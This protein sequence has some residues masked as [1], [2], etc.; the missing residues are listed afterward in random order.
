MKH[1]T[2]LLWMR[3]GFVAA[4]GILVLSSCSL[5]HGPRFDPRAKAKDTDKIKAESSANEFTAIGRDPIQPE[6]LRPPTREY[7]LGPGDRLDIEIMGEQDTHSS[8]VVTPDGKIY[9]SLVPGLDVQGRTL[10]QVQADLESKLTGLYRHPQVTL[11]LTEV[12]SERIWVLGRLYNP[13]I[14]PLKR[15]LRVLD[16]ISLA[17]GL[18]ASRFTGTT[19]ELA[20]LRHSFLKRHGK[21]MPVDFQKLIR[22]GDLQQNVYLEPDDYIYLPSSLSSEVYVFGAVTEPRPVGFMN[23]MNIMAAIGHAAG[24]TPDA[25]LEHVTIVRGSLT[26]PK[27][28]VVNVR[29][30]A[31]GKATNFRL[32]SGDIVYV[33]RPGQLSPE[34]YV[35]IATETFVQVVGATEGAN[36]VG[37][38]SDVTL[39]ITP[40]GTVTPTITP[41]NTGH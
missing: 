6:W 15:P 27:Y 13:G 17:G 3:H 2:L 4:I 12:N 8:T 10:K 5:L 21:L 33:P 7:T 37:H 20:D 41:S 36:A 22:D 16:A 40:N 9:Y 1:D 23:E 30:I 28:A 24:A 26:E 25:D 34:H 38:R 11:T 18:F 29:A 14:F 19:E 31:A 35:K 32:E 39:G